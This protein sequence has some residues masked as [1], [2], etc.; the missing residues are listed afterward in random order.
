MRALADVPLARALITFSLAPSDLKMRDFV[1]MGGMVC[2]CTY[3][4]ACTLTFQTA[5]LVLRNACPLLLP[6]PPFPPPA[7]G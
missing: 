4:L 6:P 5:K 1:K 2:I 3:G 7:V